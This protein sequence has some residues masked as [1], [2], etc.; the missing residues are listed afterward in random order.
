MKLKV[1]K[2]SGLIAIVLFFMACNN[3]ATVETDVVEDAVVEEVV[4]TVVE[5]EVVVEQTL[6][7][8]IIGKWQTLGQDCDA[9]GNNCEDVSGDSFWEFTATEVTWSNFTHPIVFEDDKIMLGEG[10]PSPYEV[11]SEFGD[12][13]I[14]HA[15]K[16][17]RY[18]KLARVK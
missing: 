13:I 5:E 10:E 1:F 15:I 3:E 8:F 11:T 7:E 12:T 14:F 16:T 2:I 4:E 6:E 9:E 18:M 17:D